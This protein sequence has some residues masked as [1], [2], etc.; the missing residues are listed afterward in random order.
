MT[1]DNGW[2]SWMCAEVITVKVLSSSRVLFKSTKKEPCW[3]CLIPPRAG[4]TLSERVAAARGN[5][6]VLV[7]RARLKPLLI[8]G[9]FQ[10]GPVR[11]IAL[12]LGQR[13]HQGITT[14]R[15]TVNNTSTRN[16][17]RQKR[18]WVRAGG[19]LTRSVYDE[20]AGSSCQLGLLQ[21]SQENLGSISDPTFPPLFLLWLLRYV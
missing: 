19:A 10:L 15:T 4:V 9:H 21:Q 16:D 2:H 8:R 11:V 7:I 1:S 6:R 20:S 18:R 13:S 12:R 5:L 17:R 3:L 14:L